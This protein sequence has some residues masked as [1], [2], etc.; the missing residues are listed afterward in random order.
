MGIDSLTRPA[1][2]AVPKTLSRTAETV[3]RIDMEEGR[4]GTGSRLSARNR[5]RLGPS[6]IREQQVHLFRDRKLSPWTI[7]SRCSALRSLFVK[8][9]RRPYLPDEIPAATNPCYAG[10]V[11]IGF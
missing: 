7:Q 6:H 11:P 9:L 3:F 5:E 8:T 4:G 2:F 10:A 1:Y